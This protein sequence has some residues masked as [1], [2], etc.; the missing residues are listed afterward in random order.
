MGLSRFSFKKWGNEA[1]KNWRVGRL[2]HMTVLSRPARAAT[3]ELVL[4]DR[5]ATLIRDVPYNG[6]PELVAAIP[7]VK[8]ALDRLRAAGVQVGVITNQSG[9]ARGLLT[10]D[11][12]ELVNVRVEQLLGPFDVWRMCPHGPDDGCG[13]RKPAP[14]MVISACGELG[15]DPSRCVVVGDIAADVQAAQAAGATGILVPAT[16]T[17]PAEIVAARH[18]ATNVAA[19]ASAILGGAW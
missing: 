7:G 6:D 12:V 17:L 10:A 1:G 19:A 5:D 4:F 15:V 2:N 8:A 3:A 14:G 13:C 16:A 9:I 11:Q 18:V